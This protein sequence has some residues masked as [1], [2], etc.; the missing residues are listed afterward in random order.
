MHFLNVNVIIDF[1]D[2]TFIFSCNNSSVIWKF[3]IE[4]EREINKWKLV[5]AMIMKNLAFALRYNLGAKH[6]IIMAD[7]IWM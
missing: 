1:T 7:S 5:I 2:L 4:C 3:G 6:L